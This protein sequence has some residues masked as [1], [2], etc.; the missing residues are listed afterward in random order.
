MNN[1]EVFKVIII[2]ALVTVALRLLPLFVKIPKNPIMI[3]LTQYNSLPPFLSARNIFYYMF[4]LSTVT[5][6]L[7]A[8][9]TIFI[10]NTL[11]LRY[12]SRIYYIYL[13][14]FYSP[15]QAKDFMSICI[16]LYIVI[17]YVSERKFIFLGGFV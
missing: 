16:I 2:S 15:Y 1:L 3:A 11:C 9:Y 12:K 6:N 5:F 14:Y 10:N 8:Y 13:H 7:S 17:N 4:I